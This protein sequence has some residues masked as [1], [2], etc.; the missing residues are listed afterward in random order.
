MQTDGGAD[1]GTAG[2]QERSAQCIKPTEL[3]QY[4]HD[5]TKGAF[6]SVFEGQSFNAPTDDKIKIQQMRTLV[7]PTGNHVV[8]HAQ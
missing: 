1:H 7:R 8:S 5:H 3:T 6:V 4:K 2:F